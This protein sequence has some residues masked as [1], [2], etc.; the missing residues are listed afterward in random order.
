MVSLKTQNL[1]KNAWQNQPLQV[2]IDKLKVDHLV[3]VSLH[4][5]AEIN[6]NLRVQSWL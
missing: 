4:S 3:E 5:M 1:M 2:P 6:K